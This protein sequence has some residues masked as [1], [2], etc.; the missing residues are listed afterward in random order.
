MTCRLTFSRYAAKRPLARKRSRKALLCRKGMKRGTM[1]PAIITLLAPWISAV[2]PTT[3]PSTAQKRASV[4]RALRSWPSRAAST[5]AAGSRRTV[6]LSPSG[7]GPV[8]GSRRAAS[9]CERPTPQSRRSLLVRPKRW[10]I[11]RWI[12]CSSSPIGAKLT[13]PPSVSTTCQPRA[14][15]PTSIAT[16]RPV[17]GP[18]TLTGPRC[19][20]AGSP[21]RQTTSS[22]DSAGTD[23]ATAPKSLITSKRSKPS[24][25]C[26]SLR[27]NAQAR[28]VRRMASPSTGQATAM[29]ACAGFCPTSAR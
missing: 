29:A 16:P 19:G 24:M 9:M 10:F 23:H 25:P 14:A 27:E 21:C 20:R 12:L 5:I 6:A 3:L 22:G 11:Q 2:S 28:L 4:R 1:P 26:S 15:S 17:P 7:L 13:W 8:P 18:S